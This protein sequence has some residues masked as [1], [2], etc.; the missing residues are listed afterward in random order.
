MD[1][2]SNYLSSP[3]LHMEASRTMEVRASSIKPPYQY[4]LDLFMLSDSSVWCY[5]Q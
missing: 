4:Q 1:K 5:Y 3:V 2:I